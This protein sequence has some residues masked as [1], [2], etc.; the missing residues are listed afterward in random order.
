ME[1][2]N[3]QAQMSSGLLMRP[4][5]SE[6]KAKTETRECETKTETETKNYETE[7]ETCLVNSVAYRYAI[8]IDYIIEIINDE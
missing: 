2:N 3:F 7:T 5:H 8:V 1:Q 4:K 6:T